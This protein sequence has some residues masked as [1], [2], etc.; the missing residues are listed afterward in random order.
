MLALAASAL[1]AWAEVSPGTIDPANAIPPN[2]VTPGAV[3]PGL[4]TSSASPLPEAGIKGRKLDWPV[5]A[6]VAFGEEKHQL[7]EPGR[8]VLRRQAEWLKSNPNAKLL[9]VGYLN[10]EGTREYLLVLSLRLAEAAK[11]ELV[12]QGVAAA[13]VATVGYGKE[14]PAECGADGG[15]LPVRVCTVSLPYAAE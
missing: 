7:T 2:A 13:R 8:G 5:Q 9:I 11:D 3:V 10:G 14:K 15:G 6:V 4:G 12:G 1:P